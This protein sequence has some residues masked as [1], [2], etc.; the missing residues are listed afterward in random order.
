MIVPLFGST[1]VLLSSHHCLPNAIGDAPPRCL[2]NIFGSWC[3]FWRHGLAHIGTLDWTRAKMD[4]RIKQGTPS[5]ARQG[6]RMTQG[7][8]QGY[9][10]TDRVMDSLPYGK[11]PTAVPTTGGDHT[12]AAASNDWPQGLMENDG[13][14]DQSVVFVYL[15]LVVWHVLLIDYKVYLVLCCH[16]GGSSDIT[17]FIYVY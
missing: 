10:A 12:I 14:N 9:I 11:C 7:I 6:I 5:H 2:S 17:V 13:Q 3:C 4:C 15:W 16:F 8:K 1:G